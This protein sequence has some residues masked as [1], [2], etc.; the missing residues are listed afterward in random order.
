M[1]AL[2]LDDATFRAVVEA[3][4]LVS[5]DLVVRRPDG[6]LL[7]GLR[8]NRPA[9]GFWFV[10]GG[11]IRKGETL[12]AAFERLTQAELGVKMARRDAR[13]LGVYEHLYQDS[14]F[15]DGP[16]APSTHYVVLGYEVPC[17]A[18]LE[19]SLPLEQHARFDWFDLAAVLAL[20]SV[21]PNTKAYTYDL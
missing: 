19:A 5:I 17:V 12:D 11:R 13:L 1:T 9:Q 2:L 7:L 6:Q 21:H 18:E 14:V 20:D 16:Q 10:P 8:H 15:G 3:T 4:P